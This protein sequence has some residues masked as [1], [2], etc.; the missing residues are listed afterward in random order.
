MNWKLLA[1]FSS[2]Q[3]ENSVTLIRCNKYLLSWISKKLGRGERRR[4]RQT[5]LYWQASWAKQRKAVPLMG[6]LGDQI[7]RRK[8][9]KLPEWLYFKTVTSKLGNIRALQLG[10]NSTFYFQACKSFK[11][12]CLSSHTCNQSLHLS[13]SDQSQRY[14]KLICSIQIRGKFVLR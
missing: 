9:L 5:A 3:P 6:L 8:Y 4:T 12:P 14:G 2:A 13:P 7:S 1:I 10:A 11:A